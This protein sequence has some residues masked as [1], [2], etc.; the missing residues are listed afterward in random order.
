[1]KTRTI[2]YEEKIYSFNELSDTAK[3]KAKEKYL[4]SFHEPFIFT[5]SCT[6]R[7]KEIFPNSELN[8]EYS[9]SYSQGD[10]FNIYGKMAIKDAVNFVID[11]RG[12]IFDNKEKRFLQF[13]AN[14]GYTLRLTENRARYSYCYIEYNDFVNDIND[15]LEQDDYV[16]GLRKQQN[17]L[18]K[19]SNALKTLIAGM[20]KD[21]ENEGYTFFYEV[22]EEEIIDCWEAND[23]EGFDENGNPIYQ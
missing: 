11:N 15:D 7:I 9:L 8:V 16:K 13:L 4:E 5:E 17:T 10:G 20:C 18:I 1:M 3:E 6:E 2:T 21:F 12:N 23:Y 14:N 19:F 22:E